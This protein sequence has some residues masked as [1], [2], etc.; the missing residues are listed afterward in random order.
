M[1]AIM[2]RSVC[3]R[4]GI[5]AALALPL[6]PLLSAA[7]LAKPGPKAEF[8]NGK[9]VPLADVLAKAGVRLD[10]DAAATSLALVAD[11]GKAYPLIKDDGSR[12]LYGDAKLLNRP[13]R[14]TGYLVGDTKLLRVLQVHSY[15]QG[16]LH[17]VYYWCDVCTIKRFEKRACE[18]CGAPMELRETPVKK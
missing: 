17:E 13:M 6:V 12:I 4:L 10:K 8:F 1:G 11:D 15:I 5:V 2:H 14:L 7:D 16:E 9:V 3:R 18:C